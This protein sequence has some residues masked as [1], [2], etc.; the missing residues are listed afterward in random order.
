MVYID[1]TKEKPE[2]VFSN[3][4]HLGHEL[5]SPVL[6]LWDALLRIPVVYG[7]PHGRLV[8]SPEFYSLGQLGKY[9]NKNPLKHSVF[10]VN[11]AAR[12]FARDFLLLERICVFFFPCS[13][14]VSFVYLVK[15]TV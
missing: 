13:A 5:D 2:G 12:I 10:E 1:K 6:V 9:F 8:R 4:T 3:K 11:F 14:E 15:D 7:A